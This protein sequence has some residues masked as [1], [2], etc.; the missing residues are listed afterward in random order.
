[1]ARRAWLNERAKARGGHD[2]TT[3][4]IAPRWADKLPAR[5][6]RACKSAAA[7]ES[8]FARGGARTMAHVTLRPAF[9]ALIDPEAPLEQLGAGF[10]FTEGPI[11]HPV[12]HFLLFS[13]MPGDVRRR[14]DA[15]N[16][17]AEV[18]RPA[19]KCN[20]MT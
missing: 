20:G 5:L 10:L 15:K 16:G 19:N 7:K 6:S 4:P 13:D 18:M 12:K 17:V 8:S 3:L 1:M 14:W 11:W 9:E 2:R